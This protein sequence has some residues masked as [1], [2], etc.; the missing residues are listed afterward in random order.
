MKK[1]KRE[2]DSVYEKQ[3]NST[4]NK[5]NYSNKNYNVDLKNNELFIQF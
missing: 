3:N 4:F 5:N 1:T 2:N